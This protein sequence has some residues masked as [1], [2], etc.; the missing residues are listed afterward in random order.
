MFADSL[1]KRP[2][3]LTS[4]GYKREDGPFDEWGSSTKR[5]R[6]R[7]RISPL[8]GELVFDIVI[9]YELFV[10][11]DPDAT[12][13]QNCDYSFE[14]VRLVVWH[15]ED[16]DGDEDD[17]VADRKPRLHKVGTQELHPKTLRSLEQFADV[18]GY[19]G[20]RLVAD[21]DEGNSRK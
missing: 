12:W 14:E 6:F 20:P 5:V 13:E 15:K 10:S 16:A 3:T 11:D 7:K 2:D 9:A 17:T 8:D 21:S 1:P 18:L 4:K 19:E